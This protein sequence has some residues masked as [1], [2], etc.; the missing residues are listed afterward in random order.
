MLVFW[1]TKCVHACFFENDPFDKR[2]SS[3][4][5]YSVFQ[6]TPP[7]YISKHSVSDAEQSPLIPTD[8]RAHAAGVWLSPL[9]TFGWTSCAVLW[10]CEGKVL[11]F[12]SQ[13]S[14]WSVS[15]TQTPGLLLMKWLTKAG[16]HHQK[17][18]GHIG[19]LVCVCVR[20]EYVFLTSWGLFDTVS[21][22]F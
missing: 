9:I 8:A 6:I 18:K 12:N 13:V 4:Y 16:G 7:Y 20:E 22:A 19:L 14:V 5:E 11:P 10:V 17:S 3:W 2:L 21:N 1:I 15:F